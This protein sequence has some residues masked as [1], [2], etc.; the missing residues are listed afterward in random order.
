[1]AKWSLLS[2]NFLQ[3]VTPQ[4]ADKQSFRKHFMLLGNE[5]ICDSNTTWASGVIVAFKHKHIMCGVSIICSF[6]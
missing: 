3:V 6:V 2:S 1:M 4:Y 5:L